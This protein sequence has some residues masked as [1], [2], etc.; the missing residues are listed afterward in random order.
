MIN[1][2]NPQNQII[3]QGYLFPIESSYPQPPQHS[4]LTGFK[5]VTEL[6]DFH[7]D[8]VAF[9]RL[10]PLLKNPKVAPIV[11][12]ILELLPPSY[13]HVQRVLNLVTQGNL[14]PSQFFQ[15][16]T[17]KDPYQMLYYLQI[18][19]AV[20]LGMEYHSEYLTSFNRRMTHN[21]WVS[22]FVSCGGF[23][24]LCELLFADEM[25]ESSSPL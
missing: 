19:S 15:L 21:D 25:M 22:K 14:D 18:L 7:K 10:F 5:N 16:F 8:Q 20:I 12:D 24:L 9:D 17:V 6:R 2:L 23:G 11:W 13:N 4:K 3:S 1:Y